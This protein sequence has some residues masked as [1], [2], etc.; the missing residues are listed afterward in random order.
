M[1]LLAEYWCIIGFGNWV[2]SNAGS[3]MWAMHDEQILA[4]KLFCW[5]LLSNQILITLSEM[6][7][8][9]SGCGSE[10]L[11]VTPNK[12]VTLTVPSNYIIQTRLDF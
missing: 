11:G 10:L 3:L 7:G 9:D 12:P 4:C 1:P 8:G 5:M 2:E 6:G